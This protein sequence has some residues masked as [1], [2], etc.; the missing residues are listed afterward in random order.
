MKALSKI[1]ELNLLLLVFM[2]VSPT[3]I[4]TQT[5][6]ELD[7][8]LAPVILKDDLGGSIGGEAWDSNNLKDKINLVLYVTP[9]QQGVIEPLLTKINEQ[10]YSKELFET[11]LIL[12]TSATWIPNSIIEGKV[13]SKAEEDSSKTYVLDKDEVVLNKWNLSEDN[14][15][16]ILVDEKGKV[17]LV[18]KDEL[19]E[20]FENEL[21]YKIELQIRKGES[22]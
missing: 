16:I 6:V 4:K 18:Y 5:Q 2:V 8:T 14:P 15:N 1:K 13:K 17:T 20:K 19:N 21:M 10:N 12:N 11:T 9:N 3:V 7:K 22:K